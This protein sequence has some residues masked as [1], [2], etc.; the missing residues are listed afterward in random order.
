[1]LAKAARALTYLASALFLILGLTLFLAPKASAAFFPWK[2]S[3][4]VAMTI[5]GWCL[6]NSWLAWISGRRWRGRLVYAS[7]IYLG[8]FGAFELA[9]VVAFRDKLVLA[10]P[11]SWLYLAALLASL[12][13]SSLRVLPW[14]AARP[15]RPAFGSPVRRSH[16]SF[17]IVFVLFVGFLAAYGVLAPIGAPGTRGGIFPEEMSLFTLR[18]F[19]AFYL[20]LALGVVPLASEPSLPPA[21]HH[22]FAAYGLILAITAAALVHLRLFDFVGRPGG[23]VYFGAYLA[24]GILVLVAFRKYGT[25]DDAAN[26]V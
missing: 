11:L 8:L 21:L 10:S 3:S 14:L 18:S 15:A 9:V 23:L 26:M 4:F 13:G 2:V 20:A 12:G 6:G 24:V 17:I 5:G 16:R 1:M 7:M 19:A 25:G 22:S